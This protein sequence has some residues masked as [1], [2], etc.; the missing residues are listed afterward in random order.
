M[1]RLVDKEVKTT[2]RELR[3]DKCKVKVSGT[4]RPMKENV[5]TYRVAHYSCPINTFELEPLCVMLCI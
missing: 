3:S 1:Y 5:Q 2:L 4:L